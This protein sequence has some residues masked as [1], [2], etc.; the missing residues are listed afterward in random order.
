MLLQKQKKIHKMVKNGCTYRELVDTFEEPN[1]HD[2]YNKILMSIKTQNL[3]QEFNVI[4]YYKKEVAIVAL[5][6]EIKKL[7]NNIL[8]N[9]FVNK[10]NQVTKFSVEIID[11][12]DTTYEYSIS[13][14]L[15]KDIKNKI[16]TINNSS[17]ITT[18]PTYLL[19]CAENEFNCISKCNICKNMEY[20]IGIDTTD[21][22]PLDYTTKCLKYFKGEWCL[23][24]SYCANEFE[25]VIP[26]RQKD[27]SNS[28]CDDNSLCNANLITFNCGPKIF[29]KPRNFF[30]YTYLNTKVLN[31]IQFFVGQLSKKAASKALDN[32]NK[33]FAIASFDHT[34]KEYTR[35][36]LFDINCNNKKIFEEILN[37][38]YFKLDIKKQIEEIITPEFIEEV[39]SYG[40]CLEGNNINIIWKTL[41]RK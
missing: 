39:I 1:L 4:F 40:K 29:K 16:N 15:K 37:Y 18:S 3:Y 38:V 23:I 33:N 11:N 17:N 20:G 41:R 26:F 5:A 22:L 10:D 34:K 14:T 2:K 24:H 25:C 6:Y 30:E 13:V 19:T 12:G 32:Y 36:Y 9:T 35:I 27:N 21:I 28:L 31:N 7:K 8:F